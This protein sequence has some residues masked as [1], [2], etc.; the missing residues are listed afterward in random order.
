MAQQWKAL[1]VCAKEQNWIPCTDVP[2]TTFSNY[3][4]SIC[5]DS[6]SYYTLINIHGDSDR[7]IDRDSGKHIHIETDTQKHLKYM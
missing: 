1:A 2:I 3:A 5:G 4:S 6:L 7:E